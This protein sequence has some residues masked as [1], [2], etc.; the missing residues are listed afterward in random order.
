MTLGERLVAFRAKRNLTQSEMA[1]LIG[2]CETMLWR[3]ENTYA[4]P[5]KTIL[6]KIN[7]ILREENL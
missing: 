2:V 3:Y 7:E 1:A 5:K 4:K 6:F